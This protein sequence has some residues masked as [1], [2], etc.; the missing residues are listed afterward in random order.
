MLGYGVRKGYV[1]TLLMPRLPAHVY[2]S[3]AG[4][5]PLMMPFGLADTFTSTL[6]IP[7][8]YHTIRITGREMLKNI[9]LGKI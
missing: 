5:I 2:I 4:W 6:D 7:T 1:S 8:L 9:L 3:S